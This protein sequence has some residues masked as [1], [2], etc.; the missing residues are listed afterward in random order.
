MFIIPL[1]NEPSDFIIIQNYL[2]DT[3]KTDIEVS[4]E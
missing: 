3:T 4:G 2:P 1:R